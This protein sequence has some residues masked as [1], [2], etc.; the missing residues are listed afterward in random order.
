MINVLRGL[1]AS[2]GFYEKTLWEKYQTKKGRGSQ[3]RLVRRLRGT[4]LYKNTVKQIHDM[5]D[6]SNT[7]PTAVNYFVAQKDND[8]AD[9][10][11]Q[12]DYKQ[13]LN[14]FYCNDVNLN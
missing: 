2:H 11:K 7:V 12:L 5:S 1:V 3:K 8:M 6:A 14:H 4:E 13:I 9:T 10:L